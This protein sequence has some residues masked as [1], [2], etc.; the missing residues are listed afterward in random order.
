MRLANN[1]VL[2][3]SDSYMQFYCR[4]AAFDLSPALQ[5]R[6]WDDMDSQ[7]RSDG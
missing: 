7:S 6:E 1:R 5:G 3:L 4:V 2:F